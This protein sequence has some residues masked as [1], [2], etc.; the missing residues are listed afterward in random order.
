MQTGQGPKGNLERRQFPSL[1]RVVGTRTR[2]RQET[3]ALILMSKRYNS[4]FGLSH[5]VFNSKSLTWF[6]E[7][8]VSG[9]VKGELPS[10][11]QVAKHLLLMKGYK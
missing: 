5:E 11:C 9:C 8:P 3:T 4:F 10:M 2:E 7:H 6:W 1:E